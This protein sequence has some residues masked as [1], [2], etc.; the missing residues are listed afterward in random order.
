MADDDY[1]YP[2]DEFDEL[3]RNRVPQGVHRATRPWWRVWG[4]LIAV[5][6]LAPVLA[7]VIVQLAS[8][9]GD[10]AA[11]ATPTSSQT[12]PTDAASPTGDDAESGAGTDEGAGGTE[13]GS[14]GATEG[15]DAGTGEGTGG[16]EDVETAEPAAPIDKSVA[17]SVLN[18]ARVQGMA[19]RVQDA[20]VADGWTTVTAGNYQSAQPEISTVYYR[21]ESLQPA[22]QAIAEQL[23]IPTVAPLDSVESITVVLRPDFTE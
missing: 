21:D 7:I 2:P 15:E 13:G 19:G 16:T 4:P 18:G 6:I 8:S 5:V 10:S 12:S 20:L 17:V 3:G 9:G 1:P 14:E 11:P 23:G 22:A